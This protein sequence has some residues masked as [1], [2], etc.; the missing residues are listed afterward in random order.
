[1]IVKPR[2]CREFETAS[3]GINGLETA[4]ASV[5]QLV[6]NDTIKPLRFVEALSTA[7]AR[8]IPDF[9]GGSLREGKRA[10][11]TV[12]DPNLRWILTEE[13][14]RSKSHNTPWLGRELTGRPTMTVVGGRVVYELE[15]S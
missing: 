14:L 11:V 5:L 7:P 10:D 8:L 3:V 13:A 6:R 9:E 4:I 1:M 2:E 12:I 15:R